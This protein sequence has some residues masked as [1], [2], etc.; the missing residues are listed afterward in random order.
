MFLFC[1]IVAYAIDLDVTYISK[2]SRKTA[3]DTFSSRFDLSH[4]VILVKSLISSMLCLSFNNEQLHFKKVLRLIYFRKLSLRS[5]IEWELYAHRS[6]SSL[7]KFTSVR[8][9][10]KFS[11]H[12]SCYGN[13]LRQGNIYICCTQGK[14]IQCTMYL[15]IVFAAEFSILPVRYRIIY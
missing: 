14:Y 12:C 5:T 6:S 7:V 1:F 13:R 9:V 4:L 10:F 2:T 3:S 11:I 8:I 15:H